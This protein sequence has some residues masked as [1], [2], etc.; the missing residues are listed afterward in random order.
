MSSCNRSIAAHDRGS[1][2]HDRSIAAHDRGSA[3][4]DSSSAAHR[5]SAARA[6]RVAFNLAASAAIA[7]SAAACGGGGGGGGDGGSATPAT[8][9]APAA[10]AI[11][12][13]PMPRDRLREG[14]RFTWPV[15]QIPP[16]YHYYQIDGTLQDHYNILA[17]VLPA[18]FEFDATGLPVWNPDVLA[19]EPQL[20]TEPEQ[21]VTFRI[22]PDAAWYDG[23]PI[24]WEDFYWQWMASNGGNEAYRISVAQGYEDIASVARG[25]DDREVVVTFK[26]PYS[27]W[28]ALF[29]PFFPAS[30]NQDPETF[31]TGWI[32]APLTTAGP[33][34]LGSIDRTGKTITL[35]RNEKW[36]G[37][38]AKLEAL[39]FRALDHNAQIDALAN[40][41]LDAMDVGPDVNTYQ[42]ARR[43]AGIDLR[44]AG[45][46]NFR[47]ITMN[48][49][50][51]ALTDVRVRRALAM[52]IDRA[53]IAR[54]LLGPLGVAPETLNNH[55]FMRNQEGYRDNSGDIGIYDPAK[56]A[57]LLDEAGWT[58]DG[59][60]RRK[61]GTALEITAVIPSGV[62]AS[63]QEM[64]LAQNML[65]QIGV[66]LDIDTVPSPDFFDKYVTPGQFDFTVFSWMGTAFPVSSSKS[67]Y[68][69]PIE[70][71]DGL[72]IKQNYARI[73]DEQIDALLDDATRSF[74]RAA[75]AEL[76][77]QA[78]AM[79]WGEVHSLTLYQ[80]PEI[81]AAKEGLAN[82]GA[83][84]LRSPWPYEDMGWIADTGGQ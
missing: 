34:K 48:G 47:H 62:Q 6:G 69:Q 53:A 77:N 52:A 25:A 45:G 18:A 67:I 24:T 83:F 17:A 76:A 40:G 59:G 60:V 84:G 44:V 32:E 81:V 21:V 54:A 75:A 20:V 22:N 68:A 2:A 65:A 78:D 26:H 43:V 14:G 82:F 31:N 15:E 5:S 35:V 41:E 51:P 61:G 30:T 57:Q 7:L 42:R 1:A 3:A 66:T 50:S 29:S 70:G 11:D 49:T 19:S 73:G 63:R 55:I 10:Q 38:P 28:Q 79:I 12:I 56:A 58:L 74:D 4:H 33:F 72:M 16:N 8:P 27:D 37:A 9:S 23:T 46:P 80:R 71:P 39:V 36:W 13:N 64:E